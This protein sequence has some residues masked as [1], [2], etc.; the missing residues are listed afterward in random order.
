MQAFQDEVD[1]LIK[2]VEKR[3][4]ERIEEAVAEVLKEADG[5]LFQ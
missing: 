3:A 4:Q 5:P 1:S 2:R